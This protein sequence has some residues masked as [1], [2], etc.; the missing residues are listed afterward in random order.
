MNKS[1]LAGAIRRHESIKALKE[2]AQ[3]PLPTFIQSIDTSTVSPSAKQQ[4]KSPPSNLTTFPCLH[5]AAEDLE[6]KTKQH[7]QLP[8]QKRGGFM[9]LSTLFIILLLFIMAALFFFGGY[10]FS[11]MHLPGP[12]AGPG[13]ATAQFPASTGPNWRKQQEVIPG[14]GSLEA[15][16][17]GSSYL[18]R[19]ETLKKDQA[20]AEDVFTQGESRSKV[21][22]RQQAKEVLRTST[23]KMTNVVRS[24][25]GD[26]VAR[27]FNPFATVV[28]GGTVGKLAEDKKPQRPQTAKEQAPQTAAS[29]MTQHSG[30]EQRPKGAE[31]SIEGSAPAAVA[32]QEAKITSHN[33]PP[34]PL[35]AIEVRTFEDDGTGAWA[36]MNSLRNNGYP[37]AYVARD[38]ENNHLLFKVRVGHFS[39]YL[40]ASRARDV[41]DIPSRVVVVE[42]NENRLL[43]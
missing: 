8:T 24:I 39:S 26:R 1:F 4:V 13:I 32:T 36:L 5:Q 15:A 37:E 19:R 20:L 6:K 18:E 7:L 11:Y 16:P 43:D 27:I 28:V 10:I 2:R 40:D 9:R 22:A 34:L 21:V 42:P 35:Y 25:A 3:E 17:A 31:K 30:T 41:L 33:Q 12:G 23:D 29:S 38:F 14:T